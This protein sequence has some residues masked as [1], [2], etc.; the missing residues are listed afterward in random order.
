MQD[1]HHPQGSKQ[2]DNFTTDVERFLS[3]LHPDGQFEIRSPKCPDR[4]GVKYVSTASGY[5]HD[6]AMAAREVLRLEALK[7]PAVYVTV[8]PVVDALLARAVNRIDRSKPTSSKGDVFR[9]RWLFIDIDSRRPSG[10]SATDAE[11]AEADQV[12]D[13]IVE[14]LASDGW[15]EPLQ[16]M[17]GNG[18][19]LFYRIDLP[20]DQESESLI[21]SVLKGLGERF[22]TAGAE[23]DQTPFD[24]N[25]ICKVLGTWARK[26]DTLV[27]VDGV[28]DRPHRQS[29]FIDPGGPLELTDVALLRAVAAFDTQKAMTR[30]NPNLKASASGWD[31]DT[32]LR[33]HHVPVA[34]PMPYEGGRKWLFTELPKCCEPHGH[35]F[36]GSSCIIARADGMMGAMCQHD[37]CSWGWRD[38]RKAYEPGCSDR[39]NNFGVELSGMR[40][41][42][43]SA[44]NDQPSDNWSEPQAKADDPWDNPIEIE[45][46]LVPPFPVHALPEPLRAWVAAVLE[47]YQVPAELPALLALAVC[48]GAVARRIEIEAGAGWYEPL[49][50]YVAVLLDPA[51]RKS[52]VFKPATVPIKKIEREL[53]ESMAPV[54]ARMRSDRRMREASLKEL[55]KKGA[56]GDTDAADGARELS[57]LLDCEPMPSEPKLTMDDATAEAVEIALANHGGRMIVAG[58]EG[59]LFDVMAGRY[60]S[61]VG[62]LDCFLKGHAGDDLRV[63][64]V[65]RGSI[66]V[67]R[68]CLTL[69]YAVQTDVIRGMAERPSFRGRGLIGRFIYA[70]PETNLGRRKITTQPVPGDVVADYESLIRR[71]YEMAESIG[72]DVGVLRI[73]AQAAERFIDWREEVEKLL[74]DGERLESMRDWGGKLC[75]LTARLAAIITLIQNGRAEPWRDPV[76][77]D[78]IDAAITLARW[79]LPH[80]EAVIRLMGG[81]DGPVDDAVYVLR[82]LREH[83]HKEFTRRDVHAHGRARFDAEPDRLD[84]ALAVLVDRGW[85][86]MID[87]GKRAG[88]GRPASPRYAPHPTICK[89]EPD[90]PS[91]GG[92]VRVEL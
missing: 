45:R 87:D 58:C 33:D 13:A 30:P 82:W 38:L 21:K 55:E 62:N 43:G 7:P 17:S 61:G 79:A 60:S 5:F 80:A 66:L 63:D 18:R 48:G 67:E 44:S 85:V 36:D 74:G 86:R 12:S 25:R 90:Q 1:N 92:R 64:R 6:R 88:A 14:G 37:H 41:L 78:A 46:P 91:T 68:C 28:D 29:W 57:E 23:V 65:T 22:N 59:G 76:G 34:D 2:Y 89:P 4:A 35:G 26:G 51:S 75:G 39:A 73:D 53:A 71:L 27:G 16:G 10:V 24:A 50:L 42:Q 49:N 9:R 52:G 54:L 81:N 83:R 84:G 72:D 69:A 31:V 77:V 32:W 15:P 19:Y 8:N 47:C 11:L 40:E 56:K 70:L 20:N 3:I